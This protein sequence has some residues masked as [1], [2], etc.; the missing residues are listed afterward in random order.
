MNYATLIDSDF[1]G[2]GE[3]R[4]LSSALNLCFTYCRVFPGTQKCAI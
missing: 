3:N 4:Q 1:H 2:L